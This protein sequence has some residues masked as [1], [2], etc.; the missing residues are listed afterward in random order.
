MMPAIAIAK[1]RLVTFLHSRFPAHY[2][3]HFSLSSLLT[4]QVYSPLKLKF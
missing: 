2:S 3:R 1:V 4:L